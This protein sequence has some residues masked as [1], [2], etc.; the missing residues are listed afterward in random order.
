MKSARNN[1]WLLL[2]PILGAAALGLALFSARTPLSQS[3]DTTTLNAA[4]SSPIWEKDYWETRI[5]SV[6]DVDAYQEL[7][8][9]IKELPP[10]K[11]HTA[12]HIFGA[13]LYEA[14]G[15]S[16]ITVCDTLFQWGCFHEVM[17]ETLADRGLPIIDTLNKRCTAFVDEIKSEGGRHSLGHGLLAWFGYSEKNLTEALDACKKY[18][19]NPLPNPLGGCYS[20]VFMEYSFRTMSASGELGSRFVPSKEYYTICYHLAD[21]FRPT[22]AAQAIQSWIISVPGFDRNSFS[23]YGELCRGFNSNELIDYCYTG[24]GN[25]L[26]ADVSL[27]P[28]EVIARCE[29]ASSE[30]IG[31][32]LCRASAAAIT[33]VLNKPASVEICAGLTEDALT[34]CSLFAKGEVYDGKM[35]DLIPDSI[36]N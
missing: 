25:H 11:Q 29:A 13:A 31:Q 14:E 23:Q 5:V 17:G 10:A 19:P 36:A 30:M 18:V 34:Y 20:G 15:Y 26:P 1:I 35:L 33:R 12:S 4:D 6:G 24:I 32:L 3:V 9:I 2:F 21:E 16:S 28:S 7:G 8:E 27:P 22:C